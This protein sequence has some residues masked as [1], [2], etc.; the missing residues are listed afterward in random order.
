MLLA[1][2]TAVVVG[3][4]VEGEVLDE[5]VEPDRYLRG[6]PEV[7]LVDAAVER[8]YLTGELLPLAISRR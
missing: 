7:V 4:A 6:P 8:E 2:E 3:D 1:L 5:L